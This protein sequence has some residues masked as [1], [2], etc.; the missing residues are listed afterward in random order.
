MGRRRLTPAAHAPRRLS[1]RNRLLAAA[2][3]IS[4]LLIAATAEERT[5]G[6]V[7]DEQQML[8]SAVSLASF[9]EVG[10]GRGQIFGVPRAQGD[11][12]S[13]Y[14]MGLSLLEM[15]L[16]L[17][18]RPFETA[19]GE[20]ASQTLFVFLQV[21][22]VAAAAA[23]A[24]LLARALGAGR[25]GELLAV[26]ATSV[27]SPLWA[28]PACGFSEP[29]QAACLAGAAAL[30][31][32]A[33]NGAEGGTPAL[34]LRVAAAAG[35]LA[36]WALLTKGVSAP[37]ATLLLAPLLFDAEGRFAPRARLRL[38]VAAAGG[39]LLPSLAWLAFEIVRFGRPFGSYSTQ[40]FSH[41]VLDGLWRLVVGPNKGLLFYFPLLPVAIAGLVF[42]MKARRT[43]ASGFA[44]AAVAAGTWLLYAGWWAWD[45]SHGWG[46]RFLVPLVP[47]LAAPAGLAVER[48][49]GLRAAGIALAAAGVLVNLLGVLVVE[50]ASGHY[51]ASTGGV[52]VS[53]EEFESF[54]ASF[55]EATRQKE[56]LLPRNQVARYDAAFA[57]IPLHLWL[58][59]QRLA[60]SGTYDL[61]HRLETPPWLGT[62]PDARPH[63]ASSTPVLTTVTPLANYLVAPFRWPHLGA[64]MARREGDPPGTFNNVWRN[65]I[66]D[67]VFRNLDI[68]RPDRA[69]PLA[70]FLHE[71]LPSGYSAAVYAETLRAARRPDEARRFLRSIPERA[72]AAPAVNLV[73]ALLA[74]DDGDE[75]RGRAFLRAAAARMRTPALERALAEPMAAWPASLRIFL[76][77]V[78][79]AGTEPPRG[80]A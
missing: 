75:E 79:D 48:S 28:Y 37:F 44:L 5:F 45:G 16:A 38:A 6:T 29:L 31:L 80:G 73:Q 33:A 55:R 70:A 13:P 74:R 58:L 18:A 41:G 36:G 9:G 54:P 43:R 1:D 27:A 77:D 68:G 23:F 61:V 49:K 15:P 65:G 78:P 66:A 53:R 10:I 21:L 40:R 4:F 59:R 7:S 20:H 62:H 26:F 47:L 51:I 3:A 64:A 46:P 56:L 30:A 57:P 60:A 14:G 25:F 63:V 52:A 19:F 35:F 67:Q 32:L 22:L 39:A 17:V 71:Q 50:A 69:A 24:G 2:S 12:V 76:T 42:S 72:L 8:Y 11:A 34:S